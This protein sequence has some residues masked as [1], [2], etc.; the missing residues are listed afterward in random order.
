MLEIM[1]SE[2]KDK[3]WFGECSEYFHN[4][5][6]FLNC[7]P[8]CFGCSYYGHITGFDQAITVSYS[9]DNRAYTC[10]P[11]VICVLR[12]ERNVYV[13]GGVFFTITICLAMVIGKGVLW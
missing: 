5:D 6:K 12:R 2:E 4:P 13:R 1:T 7:R 11:L 9:Q 3:H 10:L 8:L